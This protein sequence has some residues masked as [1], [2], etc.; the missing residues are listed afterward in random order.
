MPLPSDQT[1]NTKLSYPTRLYVR[2]KA[3]GQTGY[4]MER[5]YNSAKARTLQHNITYNLQLK[6]Q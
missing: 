2:N 3:S 6:L 4:R 5:F 1:F